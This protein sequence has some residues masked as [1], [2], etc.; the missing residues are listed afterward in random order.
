MVNLPDGSVTMQNETMKRLGDLYEEKAS[1]D[2]FLARRGSWHQRRRA[3]SPPEIDG[4]FHL[5]D[6]VLNKPDPS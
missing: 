4:A 5:A 6:P 1:N 3:R 2:D